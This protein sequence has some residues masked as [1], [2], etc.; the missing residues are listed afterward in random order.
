M[1]KTNLRKYSIGSLYCERPERYG[2]SLCTQPALA[3]GD[4]FSWL[5]G[6]LFTGVSARH[7]DQHGVIP[8][9]NSLKR[10]KM[11]T[12]KRFPVH[13]RPVPGVTRVT[14]REDSRSRDWWDHTRDV[15]ELSPPHLQNHF[16]NTRLSFQKKAVWYCE[17]KRESSSDDLSSLILTRKASEMICG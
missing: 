4:A 16:P 11:N 5:R 6:S 7:Y 14:R 1:A 13:Y 15:N 12:E 3:R 8:T 17:E 9:L 2:P 10:H